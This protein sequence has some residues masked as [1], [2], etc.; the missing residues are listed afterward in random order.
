MRK[1][2]L[3][4]AIIDFCRIMTIFILF[5]IIVNLFSSCENKVEETI[6]PCLTDKCIVVDWV[7]KRY[8][9]DGVSFTFDVRARRTCSDG[10]ILFETTGYD[11]YEIG[12]TY[13]D[14]D[15]LQL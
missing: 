10:V 4:E 5:A 13:C 1:N 9:P 14:L 3:Y 12:E 6:D 8:L 11:V 15:F 2:N 7:N